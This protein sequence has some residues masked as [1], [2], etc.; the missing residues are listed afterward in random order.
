M[1]AFNSGQRDRYEAVLDR[2]TN[3]KRGDGKATARCP[4]HEDR[5]NS[6]SI[7]TGED[8]R[9][10][11]HCFAGCSVEQITRTIDLQPRDLFA[12]SRR[13]EGGTSPG[14][15]RNRGTGSGC[16]LA[17]YAGLK[18]LPVDRLQG[19]GLSNISYSGEPA[20]RIPFRD[21]DGRELAVQFQVRL[22]RRGPGRCRRRG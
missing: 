8:G 9:V 21:A 7:A 11:L 14:D 20:V 13:G 5:A 19:F 18:R 22:A 3:V 6:L 12:K 15:G 10:L 2:L 17:D 16:T 4:A 1:T